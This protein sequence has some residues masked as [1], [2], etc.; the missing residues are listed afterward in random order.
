M[1]QDKRTILIFGGGLNQLEL[2]REAKELN[3]TS[4]VI[5]PLINPIGR[6]EADFF[7]QV[8]GR[9]YDTT[10]EIVVKHAVN[11]IVTAQ[12][13][14]PLRLMAKLASEFSF[15]FNTPQVIE[16]CRNKYLMKN[17]FVQANIPCAKGLLF[18]KEN[19]PNT[20]E[21]S[22][23]GLDFPLIIKPIDAF[24]SR[25]VY[26]VDN[27]AEL[28]LYVGESSSFSSSGEYLVEEFLDG[29]EYSV[30]AVTF[31]GVTGVIQITEK[32]I[33]PYPRT[34]E[35]GHLQPARISDIEKEEIQH[36]VKMAIRGLG[37]DNSATH[38]ELKITKEGIKI[39]EIGA[40]L[41]G[42]F[43][44]SYLTKASTGVS[45]DRAALQIALGEAPDITATKNLFSLIR[46]I[47]LREGSVVENVMS[48]EEIKTNSNVIFVHIFVK[49]G[50]VIERV[51][52]S[53]QRAACFIVVGSTINELE[54]I[55]DIVEDKV[56]TAIKLT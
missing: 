43:I 15:I 44:S 16:R 40:R 7:Y 56:R 48:I 3:V 29:K 18:S 20:R 46:Y 23:C 51:K 2:I 52:N 55:A 33:T 6:S 21:L 13:E 30:E 5:D 11:G 26:K 35:L 8:D 14:N 37:I 4:V 19:R 42:D 39:I 54:K 34:V 36:I 17:A 28:L 38:T 22:E 32:F 1:S 24:S 9:D 27:I 31:K 50:E 53:A 12:M 10:K 49:Q 47:E 41:G 45:M 25:G